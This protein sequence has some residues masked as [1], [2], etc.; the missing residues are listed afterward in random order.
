MCQ[1]YEAQL[2]A[3]KQQREDQAPNPTS[4]KM[5]LKPEVYVS[6]RRTYNDGCPLEPVQAA[7]AAEDETQPVNG[8]QLRCLEFPWL[9][10]HFSSH[11]KF[12]RTSCAHGYL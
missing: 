4:G 1:E 12:I 8:L 3:L 11:C 5:F 6:N 7:A 2:A 9:K 10:H